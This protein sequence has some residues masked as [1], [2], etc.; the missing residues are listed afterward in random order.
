[1]ISRAHYSALHPCCGG[2]LW[3]VTSIVLESQPGIL[4]CI[5]GIL[6]LTMVESQ[7]SCRVA[8]GGIWDTKLL[9]KCLPEVSSQLESTSLGPL[10]EA[11]GGADEPQ[12]EV[13]PHNNL[14]KCLHS[15]ETPGF[16]CHDLLRAQQKAP[17][18]D[19]CCLISEP[20]P[21]SYAWHMPSAIC[22]PGQCSSRLL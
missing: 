22:C 13:Q 16:R 15:S 7:V 6:V 5:A 20:R 1:M 8:A 11:L 10:Y 3:W 18:L 19:T 9:V 21:V 14:Q 12:A 17:G 2:C 4:C